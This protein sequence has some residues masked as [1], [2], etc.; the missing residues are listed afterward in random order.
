MSKLG[1]IE[2]AVVESYKR[3][4]NG[5]VEGYKKIEEDAVEGFKKVD[6]GRID[7][8]SNTVTNT[9]E[10]I[11]DGFVGKYLVREGESVEDA[12]MRLA[13]EQKERVEQA[14]ESKNI[15]VEIPDSKEIVKKN[16]EASLNAGKRNM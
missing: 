5:V 16:L 1:K 4:E 3:I 14:K 6:N 7:K 9:F 12:K 2:K 15:H 8:I 11:S 13:K 10:K